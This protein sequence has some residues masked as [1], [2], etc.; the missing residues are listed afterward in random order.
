[1][2]CPKCWFLNQDRAKFCLQCGEKL[3]FACPRCG[4]ILPSVANF[5]DECG[6]QFE[7]RE[8]VGKLK[9]ILEDERKQVTVLFSDLTGYTSILEKIDPEE[10]KEIMSR[11]FGE[12]ALVITKYEGFIERFYGDEVMALFGVPKIHE[13]DPVRAIRAAGEIHDLVEAMSPKLKERIGQPLSMHSGINTGLVV[14]SSLDKAEGKHEFIG[15]TINLASRLKGL[16]KAGEILVGLDTYHQAERY[17]NFEIL[18][19]T[20]VKGKTEPVPVYQVISK[21][22]KPITIH[23]VS[24]LKA[25]LIGRKAELAQLTEAIIRL[26]DGQGTV[27]AICGDAGTGKSRLVEEFKATIDLKTIQWREG[28]AYSYAQNIPYFLLVDLFN[29]A[30]QIE[31]TDTPERVREKIEFGIAFLIG[32]KNDVVPYVGGLY[33]LS[34]PGIEGVTPEV[35]KFQLQKAIQFVLS[36]LVQ[37][38]PTV[39]FLEDLHW[40]DPS[41]GELL[42]L[43]LSDFKYPVLFLCVYR[44]TFTLF[45]SQQRSATGTSY[46]EIQL[47]DLSTAETQDMVKSLLKTETI[48]PDLQQFL[49]AKVEGNPFYLEEI[50]NSLIESGTLT[51]D[52]GGWRLTRSISKSDIPSTVQG[53]ISAR[54]DRLE[55]KMKRVLQESSVI[56]R[57]FLYEIIRK[58]TELK[59]NLDQ[60]LNGLEQ[61]DL[62]RVRSSQPDLEYIFKHALIQEVVYSSILKKERQA[63]HE[64]V[65][66]VMEQLFQERLT[67]FYEALAFHFA[68]GQSPL[69][70]VDYL[71]KSGEKSLKKYS[72]EEAHQYFKQAFDLIGT[73][74]NKS[75]NEKEILMYLLEQWSLVFYYRGDFKGLEELLKA[76]LDSAES[77]GDKAKLGI[78]YAWL[79]FA[80]FCR[81]KNRDS[82]QFLRKALVLGEE[83]GNQKV[84]GYACTWLPWTC[85]E[86]ALFEEGLLFGERALEI[87][88]SFDPDS[89]LFFQSLAGMGH[90]YFCRGESK[91]NFEI[92]KILLDS[93]ERRSDNRCMVASYISIGHGYFT[94]GNFPSAI[95][96]YQKAI[97]IS[98]DPFYVKWPRFFLGM[99]YIQNGQFE[100]AKEV[101]Q[102]VV[103]YS[104][105]F[106]CEAIGTPSQMFLGIVMMDKGHMSLG[107][108][109]IKDGYQ[110]YIKNERRFGVF[111]TDHLLGMVFFQIV[112]GVG[113][114]RLPTLIK[115]IVFLFKNFP[116]AGRKAEYHFNKAIQDAK[117]IGVK[118][119]LGQV[120]LSLGRLHKKKGKKDKA[121]ECISNAIEIFEQYEAEV[122]LKQAKEVL[123]S[124]G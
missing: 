44:P 20:M 102:E 37:K 15:E 64:R 41:S 24:G 105:N 82:Y 54:L 69:K 43:I 71:I 55:K 75:K 73:K 42:R 107:L 103:S 85:G 36:G 122:Y 30:F 91:K 53:V 118:G 35:W 9:A 109:M 68:Q 100:E 123:E 111:Y 115:N 81:E 57:S 18:E 29:R 6:E 63:I 114:V 72:V 79:G 101:F 32:E 16:A 49:Q 27:F 33:A 116:F 88:R 119:A 4:K 67:E 7:T 124:L 46:Y 66:W 104:Q 52:N 96:C 45:P 8:E 80:L 77:L 50:M 97:H 13:D 108:K 34:Y 110:S 98:R 2:K 10:V 59:D 121:R 112:E 51:P 3:E 113:T 31:E 25:D 48:P 120:Y 11:I 83:T 40:A 38:A 1:M 19:R 22:E 47:Q 62:I 106:G 65:A 70:A 87:A 89:I 21:K 56:G 12:I 90:I 5:C 14:T 28:H 117:E 99:G 78:L 92:G 23:R 58:V 94:A 93:A 17:F 60:Y 26:Q 74:P 86:L 61:L 84:I 39:I 95:E 76:H